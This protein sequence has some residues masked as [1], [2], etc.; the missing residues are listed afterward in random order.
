MVLRTR[1]NRV[2]PHVGAWIETDGAY[3]MTAALARGD[4]Y[5]NRSS[6]ILSLRLI[7]PK[8]AMQFDFVRQA[9]RAN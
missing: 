7:A 9:V 1:P 8:I 5:T 3:A 2:A 6:L 4:F